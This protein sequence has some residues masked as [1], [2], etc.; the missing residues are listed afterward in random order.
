MRGQTH[1]V[2]GRSKT[3]AYGLLWPMAMGSIPP[4]LRF[5]ADGPSGRGPVG[6]ESPPLQATVGTPL[7]VTIW[8]NDDSKRDR[9]DRDQGARARA[10]RDQRQLVQAHGTRAGHVRPAE[11]EPERADRHGRVCNHVR[12]ARHLPVARPCRQLRPRRHLGRQPVLL[13]QRLHQ[14]DCEVSHRLDA[15]SRLPDK[16]DRYASRQARGLEARAS[17]SKPCLSRVLPIWPARRHPG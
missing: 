10:Q 11:G 15:D 1:K 5:K 3:G 2:P 8:L 7:S 16:I 6:I 9:R 13:D 4:Q 14:G 12:A 17:Q